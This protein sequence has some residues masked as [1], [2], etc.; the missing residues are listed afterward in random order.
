MLLLCARVCMT[1]AEVER[2]ASLSA[3]PIDYSYLFARAREQGVFQIVCH[4]IRTICGGRLPSQLATSLWNEFHDNARRQVLLVKEMLT[5][6][7]TLE[8]NGIGVIAFKGAVLA[9]QAYG[10]LAFRAFGDI[11]VLIAPENVGK[12]TELLKS[13]G[14]TVSA[15]PVDQAEQRYLV[16]PFFMESAESQRVITFNRRGV[17][18]E[19]HW[20]FTPQRLKVQRDLSA[21]WSR[22]STFTML[23]KT[24]KSLSTLDRML[25][26]SLHGAKHYWDRLSYI[27]D[28]AEAVRSANDL[29]W[30]ALLCEAARCGCRRIVLVGALLAWRLYR[31]NIPSGIIEAA[32]TDSDA[33]SL[34]DGIVN[35]IIEE[36]ELGAKL[37]QG[38]TGQRFDQLRRVSRLE[39]YVFSFRI[40]ERLRDRLQYAAYLLLKPTK[41]E[42][43]L[44]RLPVFLSP[45]YYIV[46]PFRLLGL[47]TKLPVNI[48]RRKGAV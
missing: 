13:E 1:E 30:D 36:M 23:G 2:V 22:T 7:S 38:E 14:Y 5:L 19:V 17:V 18:V 4:N 24:C 34:V 41:Q 28:F 47:R 39:T 33:R 27:C 9:V 26:L 48:L 31:S 43:D 32:L 11:D 21:I 8:S 20:D 40:R 37:P 46:R 15:D 35:H 42:W 29:D 3:R 10:N 16:L 45:F 44:L 12:V 25:S 6:T